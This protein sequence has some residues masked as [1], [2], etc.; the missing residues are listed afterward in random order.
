MLERIA[1][2][3]NKF[4]DEF[5]GFEL[6]GSERLQFSAY[7][8]HEYYDW[9]MDLGA[10]GAFAHRKLSVSV[11]L[12]DPTEYQGGDL[13]ISTGT[14]T[15]RAERARG[16]IILFPA[17]AMHRVLPV[18]DGVRYSIVAWIVGNRPFR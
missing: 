11:Q 3:V 18:T 15:T 1:A 9:H 6:T 4:N 10:R 17:Y 13:E 12:S 2:T 8:P 14:A 5:W 16:A 7:R